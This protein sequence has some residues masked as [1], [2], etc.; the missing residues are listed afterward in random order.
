MNL[1][2]SNPL[3]LFGLAAGVLPILI[4]RLI[5]R[6]AVLREFSAVRLLLQSQRDSASP[7]R[8]KNLL[9]LALRILAVLTLVLL[10]ARP[11]L[12]GRGLLAFGSGGAK[13]L[14]IDNSLSMGFQEEKG[15]RVDLA[16]KVARR[17]IENLTGKVLIL[18]TVPAT[19]EKPEWLEPKEALQEMRRIPLSFGRGD[20]ASA[21]HPGASR[22]LDSQ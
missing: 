2:F 7:H 3:L 20:P 17:I 16:R 8:L 22:N 14:L 9:L 1:I 6:Q 5:P 4:H 21:L 11:V 19:E 18:P 12:T 15:E 10:M 13:V